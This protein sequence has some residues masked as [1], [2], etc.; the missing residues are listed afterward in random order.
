VPVPSILA[1][2]VLS[3][4]NA[5]GVRIG[6]NDNWQQNPLQATNIAATGLQ[7]PNGLDS[8][9]VIRLAP[10]PYIAIISGGNGTTGNAYIQVY[11]LNP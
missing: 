6:Y 5:Q 9:M 3:L 2:P 7:P 4:F 8:A 10:G 11:R 1:D